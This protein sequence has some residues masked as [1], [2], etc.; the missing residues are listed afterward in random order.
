MEYF[1]YIPTSRDL[2]AGSCYVA[3]YT[4]NKGFE[5]VFDTVGGSNLENSFQAA[6]LFG[7]VV[8]TLAVGEHDLTEAFLKG[9]SIHIVL[10]PLPLLKGIKRAHY[11][12]ILRNIAELVD[13]GIIRPYIDEKRFSISEV[14]Q[15][16]LYAEQGRGIGKIVL[17]A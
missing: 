6:T 15:A 3:E 2:F 10:Q 7:Q 1:G 16:H 4:D 12:D 5:V 14:G 9:L 13:Q 11:G 17:S 8:S